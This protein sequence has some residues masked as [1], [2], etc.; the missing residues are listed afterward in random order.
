MT[1]V[2]IPTLAADPEALT[3]VREWPDFT[4]DE[5]GEMN[6]EELVGHLAVKVWLLCQPGGSHVRPST[7]FEGNRRY[8]IM[9]QFEDTEGVVVRSAVGLIFPN[10][11]GEIRFELHDFEADKQTGGDTTTTIRIEPRRGRVTF[12]HYDDNGNEFED[13]DSAYDILLDAHIAADNIRNARRS[14]AIKECDLTGVFRSPALTAVGEV[15]S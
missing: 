11:R 1:T 10:S 15:V 6:E 12:H 14:D 3:G 7:T 4:R 8:R 9:T 5:L 2:D 13:E